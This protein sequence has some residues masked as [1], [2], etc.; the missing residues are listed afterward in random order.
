M[1]P[2]KLGVLIFV[3]LYLQATRTGAQEQP[4]TATTNTTA[5]PTITTT[6]T[7]VDTTNNTI[8]NG[9]YSVGDVT[10]LIRARSQEMTVGGLDLSLQESLTDLSEGTHS[11]FSLSM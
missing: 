7:T 11:Y 4:R 2:R 1:E 10:S 8:V 6:K 9:S 3:A 5:Q